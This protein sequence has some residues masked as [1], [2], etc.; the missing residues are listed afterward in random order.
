MH[1][2]LLFVHM[3]TYLPTYEDVSFCM[4][5]CYQIIPSFFLSLSLL[6]FDLHTNDGGM[7]ALETFPALLHFRRKLPQD[8][9]L[10]ESILSNCWHNC[11]YKLFQVRIP[12]NSS[13][14]FLL[15]SITCDW[16]C[17]CKAK[18]D[19]KFANLYEVNFSLDVLRKE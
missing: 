12:I 16:K 1:D 18:I 4:S 8:E 7:N 15:L 14:K 9:S 5:L 6:L 17:D 11:V 2:S 10:I 13:N 19:T 3:C